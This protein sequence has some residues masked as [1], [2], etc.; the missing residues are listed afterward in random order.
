MFL[1][2]YI[3]RRFI[4][5]TALALFPIMIALL[6]VTIMRI[7][8]LY[9]YDDK[10][11]TPTYQEKYPAPGPAAI[12]LE[13]ALRNGNEELYR[14]VTAL[15]TKP[16]SLE[17]NPDLIMTI[18]LEADDAGYYHYLYLDLGTLRRSTYY[19]KEESNRYI[20][21]PEGYYFYQDSGRWLQLFT[22]LALVWWLILF[23][24]EL[25]SLF[26]RVGA[27]LRDERLTGT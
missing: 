14:E 5:V 18:M 27:K 21:V 25:G 6:Y 19:I 10:L 17:A 11:L 8:E 13:D 15:R 23:I 7:Q 3:R 2:H 4:W 26:F 12:A 22:P 20:M 9:R 16:K 1:K 24:Y